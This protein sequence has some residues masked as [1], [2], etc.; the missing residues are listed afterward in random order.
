MLLNRFPRCYTLRAGD[1]PRPGPAPQNIDQGPDFCGAER[2]RKSE[3]V[4]ERVVKFLH[5]GREKAVSALRC[6]QK[7][8]SD[9]NMKKEASRGPGNRPRGIWALHDVQEM[10]L[11]VIGK[12]GLG[13]YNGDGSL[14]INP[15]TG[16]PYK[17]LQPKY[18]AEARD[19][20][21]TLLLSFHSGRAPVETAI[22]EATE[23]LRREGHF[24]S[25][26]VV[27]QHCVKLMDRLLDHLDSLEKVG[28]LVLPDRLDEAECFRC[29]LS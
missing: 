22:R 7:L 23:D 17:N 3:S 29:F 26:E 5:Y 9:G 11:E 12:A 18:A 4:A 10:Q 14:K 2:S 8:E 1:P 20:L 19:T 25:V 6:S 24:L 27:R 28:I 16:Q 15:S 21:E 13:L